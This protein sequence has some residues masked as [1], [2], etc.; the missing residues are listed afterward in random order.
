VDLASGF[1][2]SEAIIKL[3]RIFKAISN[4]CSELEKYYQGVDTASSN[5]RTLVM[6]PSPTCV[7]GTSLPLLTY[8]HVIS[9]AG[10]PTSELV[11][12]GD[13]TSTIYGATLTE[14]TGDV[15][16]GGRQVKCVVKF[17]AQYSE[18]AHRCLANQ[19]LA[20]PL[21]FC[22]RVVGGLYMVV[23]EHVEAESLWRLRL[24]HKL[25]PPIVLTKVEEALN[26]LHNAG[27]VFGDLRDPNILFAASDDAASEGRVFLVDF[28]WPGMDGEHRYPATLNRENG[29]HSEVL[30]FGVMRKVHDLFMLEKLK[31]F[32]TAV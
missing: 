20:P 32:D 7:S 8:R 30:P 16:A 14:V 6:Y 24:Q 2:A 12:L 26:I 22:E 11:D 25:I 28:D 9:R 23:M 15:G 1:H 17:T 10:R 31:R 4:S 3:A 21:Y 29:Y 13:V 19:G 18:D 5:S 27:I